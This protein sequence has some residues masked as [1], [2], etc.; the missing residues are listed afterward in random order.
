MG[1]KLN[2]WCKNIMLVCG[3]ITSL[4]GAVGSVANLL[5]KSIKSEEA[6]MMKSYPAPAPPSDMGNLGMG[7]PYN[8]VPEPFDIMTY[9]P[10]IFVAGV[11]LLCVAYYLRRRIKKNAVHLQEDERIHPSSLS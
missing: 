11:I 9:M 2:N 1:K 8:P 7:G 4:V 6:A 10:E 5:L 3:T